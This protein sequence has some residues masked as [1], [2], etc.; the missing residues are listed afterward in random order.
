MNEILVGTVKGP[1][2]NPHE[3][4]F[5]TSDNSRT[6]IG[7][8]VYYNAASG[9]DEG[10]LKI[11]GS[12]TQRCLVRGLPDSFLSDP[13]TSPSLVSTLIGL[14]D[15]EVEL[16]EITVKAIGYFSESFGDFINPPTPG[17]PVYIATNEMLTRLLSP[18]EKGATGGAHIG[19][20]LTRKRDEVPIV[21]SVKDVVSTHLAVLASTGA[22]KSYTASVLIQPRGRL[23]C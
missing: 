11:I 2:E 4:C 16:Y 12:I 9:A 14:T 5:I 20:L 18:K 13:N 3:F 23:D 7:E 15:E 8:F 10:M 21:L 22:G 17:Q 6:R 19:S 1:G